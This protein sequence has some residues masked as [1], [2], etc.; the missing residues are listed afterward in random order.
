MP[1]V[2]TWVEPGGNPAPTQSIV[3]GI[4][5]WETIGVTQEGYIVEAVLDPDVDVDEDAVLE[6]L[7]KGWCPVPGSL[8][9]RYTRLFK[10]LKF[11]G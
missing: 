10:S 9:V 3:P 6:I 4:V 7:S 8:N 5:R 11:E 1:I 2:V